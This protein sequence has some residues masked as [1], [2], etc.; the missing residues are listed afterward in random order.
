M[1]NRAV[2]LAPPTVWSAPR[3]VPVEVGALGEGETVAS[4]EAEVLR[5]EEER[6]LTAMKHLQSSQAVLAEE[7][8]PEEAEIIE[9]N[10]GVLMR[11]AARL[12]SLREAL[13]R[14]DSQGASFPG[15]Q[16]SGA[17]PATTADTNDSGALGPK[18]PQEEE[19]PEVEVQPGVYV[20][21]HGGRKL[22][23][24]TGEGNQGVWL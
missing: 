13:S 3:T 23:D 10:K 7:G 16:H 24:S 4:L 19:D 2:P 8:G 9:E 14:L 21:M 22:V 6:L 1:A 5:A 12:V 15:V 18:A 11:M 17:G 20:T